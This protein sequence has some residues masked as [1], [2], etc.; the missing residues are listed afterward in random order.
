MRMSANQIK[1]ASL[2]IPGNQA[3]SWAQGQS[4]LCV[5]EIGVGQDRVKASPAPSIANLAKPSIFKVWVIPRCTPTKFGGLFELA[6]K[7]AGTLRVQVKQFQVMLV[8]VILAV[9][10]GLIHRTCRLVGNVFRGSDEKS[11]EISRLDLD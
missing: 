9:P 7:Y 3:I 10:P 8:V 6:L 4:T 2:Y 11:G 1:R 5:G